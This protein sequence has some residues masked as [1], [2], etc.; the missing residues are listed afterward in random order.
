M[1][2]EKL[3]ADGNWGINIADADSQPFQSVENINDGNRLSEAKLSE[4]GS[5]AIRLTESEKFRADLVNKF[6]SMYFGGEGGN[7]SDV[8]RKIDRPDQ[9]YQKAYP[10]SNLAEALGSVAYSITKDEGTGDILRKV[11]EAVADENTIVQSYENQLV[12]IYSKYPTLLDFDKE[13]A[14]KLVSNKEFSEEK[15]RKFEEKA[16]GERQ[17][18]CLDIYDEVFKQYLDSLNSQQ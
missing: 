8:F 9:L 6:G 14:R 11:G 7:P 15:M 10:G 18:E 5:V 1:N 3:S 17:V 12:N 16:Y 4:L 2:N 13:V